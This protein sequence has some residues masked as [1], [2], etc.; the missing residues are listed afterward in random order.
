MSQPDRLNPP[1]A[2]GA[3]HWPSVSDRLQVQNKPMD[4]GKI[5]PMTIELTRA[6]P[7]HFDVLFSRLRDFQPLECV[8]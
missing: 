1:M 5:S 2:K 3:V 4:E 7:I 8:L 6:T